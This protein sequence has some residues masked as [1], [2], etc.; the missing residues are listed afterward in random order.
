[1]SRKVLD[2]ALPSAIDAE[3]SLLGAVLVNN[4]A[5]LS[6]SEA[7]QP[8]DFYLDA[9]RHIYRAMQKIY[10]RKRT[11]D[12]ITMQEEL[13]QAGQLENVGGIANLSS[14]MD[15]IPHLLNFEHYIDLVKDRSLLRQAIGAANK[16]MADCFD[17]ADSAAE[18]LER[19]EESIFRLAERRVKNGFVRL[20]DLTLGAQRLI[21][22][23]HNEREM[24]TGL[25]TGFTDLDMITSG[26]QAGDLVVI[27]ARPS[28]GK[29]ALAL[30]IA[31]HAGIKR[32]HAVGIFSLEMAKEQLLMR[33]ICSEARADAHKVRTGFST[34]ED[35]EDLGNALQ[36]IQESPIFIDDSSG[37]TLADM[38]ARARKL[39]SEQ[40]DD[41][42]LKLLIVDYLQL[43][44]GANGKENRTQE[45]TGI[46]RGLKAIA[47]EL[48][49]PVI[50]LSQLSRAPEQR[51][52]N[53]R[54][55][56][57]D[58]RES[59]SIEQDADVVLFIFREEMYNSDDEHKGKA[60]IIIAKQRNG[61][62][63]TVRL[64]Y[65]KNYTRF[66]NLL[67]M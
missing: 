23:L 11:I 50:A 56:L 5:F 40:P 42:P 21:E 14:L 18:I 59:G 19:A 34:R 39:A 63:G 62:S 51:H 2:R 55:Q 16:I 20:R 27:A 9:N 64:A 4:N 47:K 66:E 7:I 44:Q 33:M 31:A 37:L 12:L 1:M 3:R 35:L 67:E 24:V 25:Q 57:S 48:N 53:H 30:N 65:L 60:E 61:P 45:I 15:G 17:R 52:G 26:L 58:L 13:L 28:M 49:I 38:R 43:M 41:E 54:P 46:S 8:E 6:I 22:K 10:D 36:S 32:G 29:T